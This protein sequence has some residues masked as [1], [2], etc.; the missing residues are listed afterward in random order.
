MPGKETKCWRVSHHACPQA[1]RGHRHGRR[2][3]C[4]PDGTHSDPAEGQSGPFL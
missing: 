2:L 4:V 3:W 1:D